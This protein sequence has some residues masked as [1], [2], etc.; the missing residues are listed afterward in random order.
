[1]NILPEEI[2]AE[3][4]QKGEATPRYYE[5]VSVLFTDFQSFTTSS[6]AISPQELVQTL[7][8]CFTAFDE[9]IGRHDL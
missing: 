6:S 1:M 5:M 8:E 9:I 7:N 2:A 3:L 4:K